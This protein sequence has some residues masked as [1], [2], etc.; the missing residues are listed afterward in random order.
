MIPVSPVPHMFWR[1]TLSDFLEILPAKD[2]TTL[3]IGIGNRLR[4]DDYA[5]LFVSEQIN[6]CGNI[7]VLLAGDNPEDAYDEALKLKPAKAV[8]IDAAE[9]GLPAGTLQVLYEDTL[10]ERSMTTHKMP[11]PLISRLIREETGADVVILGIQP[12]CVDFNAPMTESVKFS[13]ETAARIINN[14]GI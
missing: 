11:V 8:F 4:G 2:G 7:S 3:Y 12:A 5:G 10:S 13:C 14:S 1:W 6:A 9:M